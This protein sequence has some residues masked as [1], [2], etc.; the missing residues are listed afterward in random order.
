M[1]LGTL[2]AAGHAEGRHAIVTTEDPQ[3]SSAPEPTSAPA[4]SRGGGGLWVLAAVLLLV[5]VGLAWYAEEIRGFFRLHAWDRSAPAAAVTAYAE[6]LTAG[7]VPALERLAPGMTLEMADG[8]V[9]KMKP[10]SAT[11]QM[12]PQDPAKY[13][14]TL[15]LSDPEVNFSY[16]KGMATVTAPSQAGDM[17]TAELERSGGAWRIAA[18]YVSKQPGSR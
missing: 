18:L 8:A 16:V 9:S 5:V 6:A 13:T 4:R 2:G 17:V 1:A 3:G 12:P 10:P 11:P 14:P 7:D 15:P